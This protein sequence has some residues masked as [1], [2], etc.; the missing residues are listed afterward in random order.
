[1]AYNF[2]QIFTDY[3]IPH[4][5]EGKN[6][7]LNNTNVQ[8]P[9]CDDSSNHGGF[10]NESGSYRCWRCGWHPTWKV[11]DYLTGSK[12]SALS[13]EYFIDSSNDIS[14]SKKKWIK[15]S[16]SSLELPKG[17]AEISPEQKQYLI[18][19]KFDPD[20][21]EL[22][23]GLK[24]TRY[25]G[26]YAYRIIAP[27]TLNEVLVS[28]QG[29]DYTGQAELRYKA[30][31]IEKEVLH[32]KNTLYSIDLVSSCK[33]II[34]VEGI[35]DQ[36]RLGPGAVATFGTGYTQAQ[37]NMLCFFDQIFILFDREERAQKIAEKMAYELAGMG[38][39]VERLSMPFD[40]PGSMPQDEAD[41]LMKEIGL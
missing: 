2:P 33:K 12:W 16:A 25:T 11:I 5:V 41:Y 18:N 35:T 28:Y 37:L 19:R 34:V 22:L 4:W 6:V 14:L 26:E 32:H 31:P 10:N 29:R 21:L 24:G 9:M 39:Q 8:C 15:S 36:W 40:D 3:S 30:C 13:Q 7:A 20:K 1:M 23:Y 38:K 27:I 17:A